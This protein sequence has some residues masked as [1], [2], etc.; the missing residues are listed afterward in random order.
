MTE[1]NGCQFLALVMYL[2]HSQ[3]IHGGSLQRFFLPLALYI[4]WVAIN[5]FPNFNSESW[6]DVG[7]V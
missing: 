3:L 2:G 1:V 7:S 5:T 4:L 6:I